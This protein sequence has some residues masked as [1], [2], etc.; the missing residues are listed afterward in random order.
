MDDLISRQAA[1]ET[2]MFGS[3]G[4]STVYGRSEQGMAAQKD[5]LLAIRMLSSVDA[6]EEII[7]IGYPNGLWDS[8]NN[9][10]IV[11]RGITA[12]NISFDYNGKKEFLID[13][14]C[15]P[16]SSGSPVL[17]CN[18]GA[19]RDKQGNLNLGSSRVLFVG[20]LYAGPQ[21]TVT[22]DIRIVSVPDSQQKAMSVAAIPNN[23][24]YIIKSECIL[25]FVPYFYNT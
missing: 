25:D 17:I 8:T 6:V 11:R 20:V 21:L 3:L 23:L 19:Y 13:A 5:T 15:F 24:G 2:V 22:G 4:S 7:M 10:P 12:T 16:G 1:I 18:V 14:A 9:M